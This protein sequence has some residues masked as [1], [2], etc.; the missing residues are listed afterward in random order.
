MKERRGERKQG[1]EGDNCNRDKTLVNCY[2]GRME[3]HA[4]QCGIFIR[5]NINTN[6]D[7]QTGEARKRSK[8]R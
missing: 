2:E 4:R 6:N 5:I 8:T 7:R 1:R 3:R